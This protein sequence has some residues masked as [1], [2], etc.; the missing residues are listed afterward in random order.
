LKIFVVGQ[1]KP[2][3]PVVSPDLSD[4][5]ATELASR[6]LGEEGLNRVAIHRSLHFQLGGKFVNQR[7]DRG[8]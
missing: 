2:L 8:C 6:V 3:K 7:Q 5:V 4:I 1:T